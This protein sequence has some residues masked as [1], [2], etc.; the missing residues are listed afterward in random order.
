MEK[1]HFQ[2]PRLP[3]GDSLRKGGVREGMD[4]HVLESLSL[5]DGWIKK[6]VKGVMQP[7]GFSLGDLSHLTSFMGELS[8]LLLPCFSISSNPFRISLFFFLFPHKFGV[9]GCSSLWGSCGG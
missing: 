4:V 1:L 7:N 9:K 8:L 2:L 3:V 6:E 5:L